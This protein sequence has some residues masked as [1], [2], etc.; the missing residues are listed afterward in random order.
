LIVLLSAF[1]PG[2]CASCLLS[3]SDDYHCQWYFSFSSFSSSNV[4]RHFLSVGMSYLQCLLGHTLSRFR[5]TIHSIKTTIIAENFVDGKMNNLQLAI[6]YDKT[7]AVALGFIS[8]TSHISPRRKIGMHDYEDSS[9]ALG[10]NSD[11]PIRGNGRGRGRG[12]PQY[13]FAQGHVSR[14]RQC[15]GS[16]YHIPRGGRG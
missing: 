10:S 15:G 3:L 2:P 1:C 12:R 6:V 9:H 16:P 5:K 8:S 14:L 11:S 13:G 7:A 4:G